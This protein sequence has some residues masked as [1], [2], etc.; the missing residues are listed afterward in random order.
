MGNEA[1]SCKYIYP[2]S[3]IQFE[4][5]TPSQSLPLIYPTPANKANPFIYKNFVEN[6]ITMN[7]MIPRTLVNQTF[8]QDLQILFLLLEE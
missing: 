2:V 5:I 3:C 6:S 4:R 8:H 1:P 7:P